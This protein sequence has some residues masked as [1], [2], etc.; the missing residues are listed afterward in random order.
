M[1]LLWLQFSSAGMANFVPHEYSLSDDLQKKAFH[2]L[3]QGYFVQADE[4]FV[5]LVYRIEFKLIY[6]PHDKEDIVNLGKV[7]RGWTEALWHV[8][9]YEEALF[10][11]RHCQSGKC[12]EYSEVR[13]LYT[14]SFYV[15]DGLFID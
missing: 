5:E 11:M 12:H 10:Q 1:T 3:E 6:L 15:L 4:L 8:G 14:L 2:C 9:R 7:R 13:I